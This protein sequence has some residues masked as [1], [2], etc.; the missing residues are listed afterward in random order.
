MIS[1]YK[2]SFKELLTS[3][4]K[5]YKFKGKVLEFAYPITLKKKEEITQQVFVKKELPKLER[6][7]VSCGYSDGAKY[8]FENGY[9]AM[10]R[11]SG[12]ENVVRIFSEAE[13]EKA[14]LKDIEKLEDFIG[15]KERQ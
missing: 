4:E 6:K 11:F 1:Y 5:E 3:I 15:V 14:C 10:I 7:L 2:K 13:N 8:V 9:W 12:N